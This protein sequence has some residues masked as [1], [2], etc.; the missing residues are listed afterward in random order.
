MNVNWLI[1]PAIVA[2]VFGAY[3]YAMRR[4]A[5]A[6]WSEILTLGFR[7]TRPV[8]AKRDQPVPPARA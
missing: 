5:D 2:V 8:E 4:Y 7:H 3:C 1:Y 6:Q